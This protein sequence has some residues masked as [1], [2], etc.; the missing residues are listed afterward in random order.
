MLFRM[1]SSTRI[2]FA[3]VLT[4]FLPVFWEQLASV[5]L[6]V[7]SS[8]I[9][10]NIDPAYLN[11]TSLVGSAVGPLTTVYGSIATGSAILMSQYMGAGDNARARKLFATSNLMGFAVSF[12]I[13]A[14][15][16]IFRAP[17]LS[18]LYPNM[19]ESFLVNANIYSIFLAITVPMS[20]FRTNII[21]I[22]RGCLNTKGPLYISLFGGVADIALR[23]LFMVKFS[24]GIVGLGLASVLSNLFFTAVS[25]L[26]L[27]KV[28][29]FK[30]CFK[31]AFKLYDKSVAVETVKLGGVVC[32][33]SFAV[34]I[35]GLILSQ[36]FATMGDTEMSAF[37]IA[38]SAESL[39][40]LAP[41]AMAYV[42]QILAG[43]YMGAGEEKH[44]Y[45]VSASLTAISTVMHIVISAIAF[46]LSDTLVSFYTDD[47]TLI[48]ISSL[49]LKVGLV[50]SALFW[51]TGNAFSAGIRGAGNV[52]YP[53]LVLIL[54]SWLYKIPATWL[55][56]VKL[57]YGAVGRV[58]VNSFE[59]VVFALFFVAFGI[60]K[61][62]QIKRKNTDEN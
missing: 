32:I 19:S 47:K 55:V 7:V 56:C 6:S 54:S 9:S 15:I 45:T 34:A 50:V 40:N 61:F 57:D 59:Q 13:S 16:I 1:K 51:S 4:L 5:L 62:R 49:A 48:E 23:Y 53:A 2:D 41:L 22:L 20:F 28:G 31:D 37:N 39:V 27:N 36:I 58:F 38:S 8:A 33:Q 60:F 26:I 42:V 12:L 24:L 10:T 18:L 35:C 21:G 43:K 11:A 44:A 52:K 29:V 46:P 3:L 17:V 30:G 25:L 14:F